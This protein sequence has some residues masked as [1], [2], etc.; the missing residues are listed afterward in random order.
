MNID[1][2]DIFAVIRPV[3][4]EWTKQRK[5]EERNRRSRDSRR[6][7]YSGR[8]NFT[9]IAAEIFPGA[10]RHASHDPESD[11]N[12]SVSKRQLFYACRDQFRE[13]AG[14]EIKWN[15]FS[16]TLLVQFRN[17]HPELT[18]GWEITADPRGTLIIPN[19]SH[20]V[21]I[22]CGTLHISKYLSESARPID[23]YKI[24]AKLP[25]EFPSKAAG[26]RYQALLY[27][28]K[29]GFGP[30]IKEAGIAEK[31]DIAIISNKGQSVVAARRLIDE[32]CYVGS[33]CPLLIVH[34]MDKAGFEI[35]SRLTTVADWA[36]E[37]DRVTYEFKNKI[38]VTDLGL[39]LKDAQKYALQD[40]R[41]QFS[42]HFQDD[43]YATKEEQD[44]LK[45]N[46]RI[47]LNAFTSPQFVEWLVS[48]LSKHLKKFVPADGVLEDAYRRAIAVASINAKI[49]EAMEGAIEEARKTKIPMGLRAKLQKADAPW[50]K[51]L[52]E[53]VAERRWAREN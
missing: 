52:Y 50:D 21:E 6:H 33:G 19:C 35:A 11:R 36:R 28:E 25:V 41:F 45:S 49:E 1:K 27:I 38:E 40:E 31:F 34:D 10:Y 8:V 29:E 15:Y 7:I 30:I 13:K 20:V 44:F 53:L 2:D 47:E 37:N 22:P 3:V 5:A 51:A 18:E 23:P 43:T 48:K 24:D 32:C 42:G 4:K 12:Y 46:R 17:R 9:K 39:T 16:S 14:R 26:Q